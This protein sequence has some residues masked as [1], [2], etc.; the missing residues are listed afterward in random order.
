MQI[1]KCLFV[2]FFLLKLSALVAQQDVP[3]NLYKGFPAQNLKIAPAIGL[4]PWPT[5]DLVISNL[6]QWDIKKRLSL[7]SYTAYTYNSVF[8]RDFNHIKTN[9]NYSLS[10]KLGVG[11]TLYSKRAAHTFSLLGGIKYN[12]FK[13]TL[14]NPEFEK[15]S[16]SVSSV[17]PDFGGMYHLQVGKKKYFFSYRMYLPLYPYPTQRLDITSIDGNMANVSLEFGLGIR[18]K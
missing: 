5:S 11:T 10:Q 13:E 6:V 15:V 14:E 8:L 3:A 7:L 16:A 18:L 1:A 2:P 17:S 9:Y 12:S 4:N